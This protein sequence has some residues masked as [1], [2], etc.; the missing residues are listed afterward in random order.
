MNDRRI[1][2][3]YPPGDLEALRLLRAASQLEVAL[4]ST[5]WSVFLAQELLRLLSFEQFEFPDGTLL[6][7]LSMADSIMGN[8]EAAFVVAA[9]DPADRGYAYWRWCDPIDWSSPEF[10]RAKS[11]LDDA[12]AKSGIRVGVGAPARLG[13]EPGHS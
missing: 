4:T 8:V 10:A 3:E 11:S 6:N 2:E 12:L 13:K 5:S 1:T 9:L 7:E